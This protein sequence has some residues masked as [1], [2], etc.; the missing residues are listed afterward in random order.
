[1]T[2]PKA[3]N[4]ISPYWLASDLSIRDQGRSKM[5][6]LLRL[7][8]AGLIALVPA[9][10]QAKEKPAGAL[11]VETKIQF[12][13]QAAAVR[14]QL[15]VGGR[16]EFVLPAERKTIELRLEQMELLLS[17]ATN[18]DD[19]KDKQKVDLMVAQEE[20]NAILTKRDGKRLICEQVSPVG[21]HRKIQQCGTY[22]D[23]E[24]ERR[25][26]QKYMRETNRRMISK[27]E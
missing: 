23:R 3:L 21:S 1:M 9:F 6:M 19:L 15:D 26:S 4:R 25:E 12:D 22:A 17:A 24:R 2:N 16:Y 10:A 20:I 11:N 14:A 18:A 7:S 5:T 8:L 13:E 27:G